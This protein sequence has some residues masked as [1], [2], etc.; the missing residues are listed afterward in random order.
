MP[1]IDSDASIDVW[2]GFDKDSEGRAPHASVDDSNT[3][4]INTSPKVTRR[5]IASE[6]SVF[7]N[8]YSSLSSSTNDKPPGGDEGVRLDNLSQLEEDAYNYVFANK[9]VFD[10]AN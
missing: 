6:D 9:V 1:L 3:S 2:V 10:S 5:S 8:S 4:L 7:P